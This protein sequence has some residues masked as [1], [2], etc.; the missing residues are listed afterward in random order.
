MANY[1]FPVNGHGL[2]KTVGEEDA[3]KAAIYDV[4][5]LYRKF[6]IGS[7]AEVEVE[8]ASTDSKLK[9]F[10]IGGDL[11][12]LPELYDIKCKFIDSAAALREDG[13]LSIVLIN[14]DHESAQKVSLI[15]PKDYKPTCAWSIFGDDINSANRPD[16]RERVKAREE[17]LDTNTF[18]IPPCGFLLILTNFGG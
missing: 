10:S 8:G 14:R 17:K 15:L 5:E 7:R 6:M 3:Y 13:S 11:N 12:N 9:F 4:F 2:I 18:I 16:D 1:I